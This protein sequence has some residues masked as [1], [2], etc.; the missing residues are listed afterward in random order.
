MSDKINLTCVVC[1]NGCE[2]EMTAVE[3]GEPIVTGSKCPKGMSYAL[4]EL[5]DPKRTIATSV[6]VKGGQFPLVSVRTDRPI[7]KAKI[8][9][10]MKEIN[11]LSLNAPIEI[12]TV[13]ISDV[14]GLDCNIIAT[15]QMDKAF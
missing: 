12:G 8:F 14:L 13:L 3:G 6:P 2:M 15:K 10:V 5:I 11:K 7:P 4:Q 1:P 9:D